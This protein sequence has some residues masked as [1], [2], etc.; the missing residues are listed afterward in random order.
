VLENAGYRTAGVVGNGNL[1]KGYNFDQGFS[2]YV[3]AWKDDAVPEE[4]R[5]DAAHITD[6]ALEELK[7]LASSGKFFLWIH[8]IDPHSP[9]SPPPPYHEMFVA[10]RYYGEKKIALHEGF[11]DDIGGCPG[12][13]RLGNNDNLHYYIAQYDAEIRYCDSQVKRVFDF[14]AESGLERNTLVIVSSDHGES[15]G[16]HNYYF[17]HGKFSYEPCLRVPLIVRI[18]GLSPRRIDRPVPLLDV[19]PTILDYAGVR[20]AVH[21]EGLS[22]IE[23]LRSAGSHGDRVVF[24]ESGGAKNPVWTVRDERWKLIYVPSPKFRNVMTGSLYELYDLVHDPLETVNIYA[25]GDS[26]ATQLTA[27]LDHWIETKNGGRNAEG[28]IYDVHDES[29]NENLRALGYIE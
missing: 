25:E 27:E 26:M 8:Y 10:D 2:V 7:G 11:D 22:L 12:R 18:P 13:S 29:T 9:Y 15:L 6:R 1:A 17:E 21:Q 24:A 16:E 4:R 28:R 5:C 19:H 23:Q 3:E 14:I 20:S